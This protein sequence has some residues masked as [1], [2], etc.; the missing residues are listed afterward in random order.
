[1]AGVVLGAGVPEGVRQY[2]EGQRA[3]KEA[4]STENGVAI[5]WTFEATTEGGRTVRCDGIGSW[6][7]GPSGKIECMDVY[8][9]P[10]PLKEALGA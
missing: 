10:A 4:F 5:R 8:Y 6:V 7:P 3:R 1:M 2:L 9:D